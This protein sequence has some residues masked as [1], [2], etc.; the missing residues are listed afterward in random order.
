MID[1]FGFLIPENLFFSSSFIVV[2]T[3]L[4]GFLISVLIYIEALKK[5]FESKL[6]FLFWT[7]VILFV[8]WG[9]IV[10]YT[11]FFNRKEKKSKLA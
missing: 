7:V 5:G 11:L 6:H 4:I 8:P 2:S 9:S 1:L 3:T 10:Y